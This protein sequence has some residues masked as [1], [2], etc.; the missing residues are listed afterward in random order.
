MERSAKVKKR[1]EDQKNKTEKYMDE[2]RQKQELDDERINAIRL[3]RQQQAAE[4]A[5]AKSQQVHLTLEQAKE[6]ERQTLEELR[7]LQDTIEAN[8][9]AAELK[10]K[11]LREDE[12]KRLRTELQRKIERSREKQQQMDEEL[13]QWQESIVQYMEWHEKN[14]RAIVD[15]QK[16]KK[17]EAAARER[18]NKQKLQRENL[19]KMH[20]R[21]K[22]WKASVE[23]SIQSKEARSRMLQQERETAKKQARQHA[24]MTRQMR[25]ELRLN[26]SITESDR[27]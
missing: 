20:E 24:L 8:L 18:E 25:E 16:A 9:T 17:R 12:L 21:E 3:E 7:T 1:L 6:Q 22:E 5:K 26:S 11:R 13:K 14:V 4:R 15:A 23:A 2:L 27:P 10:A 19:M